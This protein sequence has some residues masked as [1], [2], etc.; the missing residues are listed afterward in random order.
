MSV[1]WCASARRYSHKSQF[2]AAPSRSLS[3]LSVTWAS[4]LTDSDLGAASHVRR[5]VSRCFSALRLR[6]L[7]HLYVATSPTTAFVLSWYHS[8]T[9]GSNMATSCLLSFL[10]IFN[11]IY[12]PLMPQLVSYSDFVATT[13]SDA[14]ANS[15]DTALASSAE[16]GQL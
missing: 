10:P 15:G 7:R 13:T 6:Q 2:L 4:T 11:D 9:P 12:S 16:T 1:I 3:L 5:T 14:L 8:S